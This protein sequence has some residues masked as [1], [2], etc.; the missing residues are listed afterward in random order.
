MSSKKKSPPPR[1]EPSKPRPL[2]KKMFEDDEAET[3]EPEER[4]E[5]E[6]PPARTKEPEQPPKLGV[7]IGKVVFFLKA[8][9]AL[10][11]KSGLTAAQVDLV[12]AA[13]LHLE[14]VLGGLPK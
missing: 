5:P 10:D 6:Q 1:Q 11:A 2:D 7:E 9:H 13:I 4:E 3:T 14:E 12:K 8:I